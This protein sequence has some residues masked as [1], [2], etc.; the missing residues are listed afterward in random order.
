MS[1]GQLHPGLFRPC[2][3]MHVRAQRRRVVQRTNPDK[4]DLLR[5]RHKC[6]TSPCRRAGQRWITCESSA[7]GRLR[8]MARG[9]AGEQFHAIGFDHR[10][11][12]EGASGLALAIAC[13]GSNART[14]AADIQP[15]FYRAAGTRAGQARNH[16]PFST[17]AWYVACEQRARRS[18]KG[19]PWTRRKV[20]RRDIVQAEYGN[21]GTGDSRCGGQHSRL[22]HRSAPGRPIRTG[23]PHPFYDYSPIVKRPKLKW[24]NGARVAVFIVPECRALGCQGRQGPYGCAQ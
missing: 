2:E 3:N 5:S 8:D 10:V 7:V 16:P 18:V 4:A 21:C 15:V 17:V 20:S 19:Y 13:N 12:H 14:S 23:L 22:R 11:Q 9:F 24:P 6:S 1:G